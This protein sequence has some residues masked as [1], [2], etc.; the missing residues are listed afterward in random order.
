MHSSNLEL[1]KFVHE[2]NEYI[3]Q[4]ASDLGTILF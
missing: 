1:D 4:L 3:N 2:V